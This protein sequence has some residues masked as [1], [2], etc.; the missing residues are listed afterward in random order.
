MG[1]P[2]PPEN[3]Y[4]GTNFTV[5]GEVE[6][7]LSVDTDVTVT[8]IWSGDATPQETSVPPY[9]ILLPFLPA[10]TT[11]SGEYTLTISI[12]STNNFPLI[13]SNSGTATYNL[14][15]KRKLMLHVNNS[16]D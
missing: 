11:S 7:D 15:I 16:H 8:G 13:I 14:V 6:L 1:V 4:N 2:S 12:R 5:I 9:R 10:T 3:P